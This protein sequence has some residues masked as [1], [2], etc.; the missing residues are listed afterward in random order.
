MR[1]LAWR[2]IYIVYIN[3]LV[4]SC[5]CLC[6]LSKSLPSHYFKSCIASFFFFGNWNYF[7]IIQ[8]EH[9]YERF[10]FL[11]ILFIYTH[12]LS[13]HTL[14][15]GCS[16]GS[17]ISSSPKIVSHIPSTK[18]LIS[19]ILVFVDFFVYKELWKNNR[20]F[21]KCWRI[22]LNTLELWL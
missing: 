16:F 20:I 4:G 22:F 17:T 18:Q 13:N 21:C 14:Y 6:S 9:V 12:L 19:Y 10:H 11:V 3:Y 15:V 8:S 5:T 2:Y 7:S 1:T